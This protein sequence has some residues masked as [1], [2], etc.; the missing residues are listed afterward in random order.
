MECFKLYL[1]GEE[2]HMWRSEGNC[3]LVVSFLWMSSRDGIQAPRLLCKLPY[4][5]SLAGSFCCVSALD[6]RAWHFAYASILQAWDGNAVFAEWAS[7]RT[8][9]WMSSQND[10]QVDLLSGNAHSACMRSLGLGEG[11]RSLIPKSRNSL[12]SFP[13]S[14]QGINTGNYFLSVWSN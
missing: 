12:L 13:T 3:W 8:D 1:S 5:L 9:E 6:D 7:V 11:C 14:R 2:A 10:G 4:T